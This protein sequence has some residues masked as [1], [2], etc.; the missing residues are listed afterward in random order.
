VRRN[1]RRQK[2]RYDISLDARFSIAQKGRAPIVGIGHTINISSSGLLLRCGTR[3]PAKT[4][5]T[6]EIDWPEAA[7]GAVLLVVSGQVVRSRPADAAVEIG[8]SEFKQVWRASPWSSTDTLIAP[9]YPVVLIVDTNTT[10]RL[11]S[12]VLARLAL[13]VL[14][15]NASTAQRIL[16]GKP[17]RI[18]VIITDKPED[19]AEVEQTV[20]IIDTD[21]RGAQPRLAE[22]VAR[23]FHLRRPLGFEDLRTAINAALEKAAGHEHGP[24]GHDASPSNAA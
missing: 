18:G 10:Y 11:A 13:P 17:L 24:E 8:H 16:S 6:V 7:A 1:E 14:H 12:A 23:I 20:Q 21:F 15:T 3:L 2:R 4:H 9:T 5:I 22:E 19:F